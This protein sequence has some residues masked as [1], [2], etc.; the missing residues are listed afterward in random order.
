[1]AACRVVVRHTFL[2]VVPEQNSEG[3]EG[4]RRHLI[5]ASSD[6]SLYTGDFREV[7]KPSLD[8]ARNHYN[9]HGEG[10]GETA[11]EASTAKGEQRTLP[12]YDYIA[13]QAS[14]FD[15]DV[16]GSDYVEIKSLQESQDSEVDLHALQLEVLRLAQENAE[17][18]QH[19]L[20]LQPGC[21]APSG[22]S[23]PSTW[24]MPV[25]VTNMP[26]TE[27][28]Q[29]PP[30]FDQLHQQPPMRQPGCSGVAA[31]P[32]APAKKS[33][34]PRNSR[35]GPGSAAATIV[36]PAEQAVQEDLRTTVM[37][38]NLPNNYTRTMVMDMLDKEG[39]QNGYDFLY[40]PIDFQSGA[41]LGYAFINLVNPS[42]AP[43][44][45]RIFVGYSRWVLP[46]RK[47]C[48]V[49]W[50]APHQ[51]FQAHVDRYRNSPV[52]HP[53]VPDDYKPVTFQNG[54]RVEFPTKTKTSRAPRLRG[55]ATHKA[56]WSMAAAVVTGGAAGENS[57]FR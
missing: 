56:H 8:E 34:K 4:E 5:R 6:P 22:V 14:A 46:S 27:P 10:Y 48:G 41:C 17:L 30:H 43:R 51:G 39:F 57:R 54:V 37:L 25:I 31:A 21:C 15:S 16:D 24:W 13:D 55:P 1:M 50:S 19:V 36:L 49:T 40:L 26:Q 11:S 23:L 29:E 32:Q 44:F 47:I 2:D 45:F 7:A 53:S 42:M 3:H 35:S 9:Y 12:C 33:S 28:I 18:K 38:R 52:M 20:S